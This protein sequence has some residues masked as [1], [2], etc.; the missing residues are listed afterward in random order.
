MMFPWLAAERP[1]ARGLQ[2]M[3]CAQ[4]VDETR[5]MQAAA[6]GDAHLV[7]RLVRSGVSV[8]CQDLNSFTPLHYAA[9]SSQL[10]TIKVLLDF[11]A[12]R[13]LCD[14]YGRTPLEYAHRMGQWEAERLLRG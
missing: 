4:P 11:G 2:R 14:S 6:K 1:A 3:V 8:N 12:D 5:L 9:G 13:S 7:D 10:P